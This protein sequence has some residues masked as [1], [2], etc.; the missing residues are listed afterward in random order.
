MKKPSKCVPCL[1]ALACKLITPYKLYILYI[2]R[3]ANI[4]I[5][6]DKKSLKMNIK[7]ILFMESKAR[8]CV[9]L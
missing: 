5:I 2:N 8:V 9:D 4:Y 7:G 6:Y 1:S 3:Y